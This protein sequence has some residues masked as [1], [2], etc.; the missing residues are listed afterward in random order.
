MIRMKLISTLVILFKLSRSEFNWDLFTLRFPGESDMSGLV[1]RLS[2][3]G[4][5]YSWDSN[6][7]GKILV[8]LISLKRIVSIYDNFLF[9]ILNLYPFTSHLQCGDV[10]AVLQAR[11]AAAASLIHVV[12]VIFFLLHFSQAISRFTTTARTSV[13]VMIKNNNTIS[14]HDFIH[15]IRFHNIWRFRLH[16][17]NPVHIIQTQQKWSKGDFTKDSDIVYS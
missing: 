8:S 2:S 4:T 15:T 13:S 10:Y 6:K 16:T 9:Q 3:N 1:C 5:W 17:F 7:D 12:F 11:C 14:I